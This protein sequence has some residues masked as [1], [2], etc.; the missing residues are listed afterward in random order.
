MVKGWRLKLQSGAQLEDMAECGR[1]L[2]VDCNKQLY[3]D[4]EA[5]E[6]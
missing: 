4:R 3:P 1:D 6:S 5:K 2:A